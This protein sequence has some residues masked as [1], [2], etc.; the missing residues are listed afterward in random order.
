MRRL[1]VD[2]DDTL[3]LWQYVEREDGLYYAT[4]WQRNDDL[5]ATVRRFVDDHPDT[6]LVIWSGGGAVYA[7]RWAVLFFDGVEC[8]PEDKN[9]HYPQPGDICVDDQPLRVACPIYTPEEFMEVYG[10]R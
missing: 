4:P 3:V 9:I 6:E 1:F 2:C 8:V 10:G 7:A 5:I